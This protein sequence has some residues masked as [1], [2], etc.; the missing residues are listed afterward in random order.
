MKRVR[1]TGSSTY[2]KCG[3]I[4]CASASPVEPGDADDGGGRSLMAAACLALTRMCPLPAVTSVCGRPFSVELLCPIYRNGVMGWIIRS[5]DNGLVYLLCHFVEDLRHLL[6]TRGD[7]KQSAR[8]DSNRATSLADGTTLASLPR[9]VLRFNDSA[10]SRAQV[11]E[12]VMGVGVCGHWRRRYGGTAPPPAPAPVE[13]L[14]SA[15]VGSG[16]V[17]GWKCFGSTVGGKCVSKRRTCPCATLKGEIED[18][19]S[20]LHSDALSAALAACG[21]GGGE[22]GGRGTKKERYKRSRDV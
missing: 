21:L 12:F 4:V 17:R 16:A 5:D 22:G 3:G 13:A 11:R 2:R 1:P 9:S 7:A 8:K 6:I 18:L 20:S 10:Y 14:A 15:I 19:P